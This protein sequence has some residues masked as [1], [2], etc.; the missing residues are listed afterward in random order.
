MS[1]NVRFYFGSQNKYDLLPEK[2][3]L[4][5]Y[6]IEDT[7]RLYKGE[8]L[9]A[10]G[11]DATSMASG[12]MSSEDKMKL[13]T[14]IANRNLTA[15]DSSIVIEN[16]DGGKSIGVQASKTEGNLITVSD[17]GLFANIETLP[18]E[19]VIG[20]KAKLDAI[21]KAIIGGVHYRGSVPTVEDLP[22]DAAQGDLYEVLDDHSEWCFNGEEWF[23]YGSTSGFIP[24]AGDG[25][26]IVDSTFSVKICTCCSGVK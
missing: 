6:F 21:E 26:E 16:V 13:E 10:T 24:V 2:N 17:D 12:L 9:L 20:L 25:I 23:K 3:P 4:A 5:L 14:L 11:T 18:L 22:V 1:Q 8:I 7:Q 19:R 15:V